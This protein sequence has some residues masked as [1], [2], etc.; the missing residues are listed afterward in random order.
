MKKL[1]GKQ[2]ISICLTLLGLTFCLGQEPE[3]INLDFEK[4]LIPEGFTIDPKAKKIYLNSL[5]NNKIVSSSIDGSNPKTFLKTNEHD[6]L[7]GFG[8]TVKGDTLYALGNSLTEGKNRS[9]L[10]LLQISTGNLIDSYSLD[11]SDSHYWNDLAISSK[12]EIFITDSQ[13]NKIYRIQRPNG[14]IQI[15]L[16]S[17]DI[18]NSNGITISDNDKL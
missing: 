6:Y 11:N 1:F 10:L 13:S 5:K 16:D 4:D 9:I 17:E 8:M 12:N 14:E 18:P 7:P 3:T 15:F 2:S